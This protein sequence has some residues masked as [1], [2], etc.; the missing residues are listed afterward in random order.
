MNIANDKLT[1][2][3]LIDGKLLA[4]NLK[5][6]I[7]A[8]VEKLISQGLRSP[9]LAV[10]LIGE[11]PASQIYVTNKQKSC[12]ECLIKSISI[13]KSSSITQS[14]LEKI[15]SDL[16]FDKSIDGIL[17]QLP[18]PNHI[19]KQKIIQDLQEHIQKLKDIVGY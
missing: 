16:N 5:L 6:N 13:K 7:K 18:L 8:E 17:V 9:C 4:T 10:V 1:N 3:G 19:D 12:E 11:D 15:I 14:E 2:S